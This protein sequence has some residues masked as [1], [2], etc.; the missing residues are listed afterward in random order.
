M[1]EA[2]ILAGGLGTRLRK[3]VS[4]LPKSLAEIND[5]PFLEYLMLFLKRNGFER[6]ILSLGYKS[7]QIRD[8]FGHEFQGMELDYAVEKE[9]LGTGG[10]IK[11]AMNQCKQEDVFVF[12]GD[13]LF[14]INLD[15]LEKFYASGNKKVVVALRKMQNMKRY[16]SVILDKDK[17][18]LK[19]QEKSRDSGVSYINGGI[20]V[21]NR[22]FYEQ[23]N[24][25]KVFSVEHDFFEKKCAQ[26]AIFAYPFDSYFIDIGVP[27]DLERAKHEFKN[28]DIF[29]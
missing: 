25:Q 9:Q 28:S 27:E 13:T 24:S 19:F 1:R 5:K 4:D 6:I 12:N 11:Y 29:S 20:Y 18:I 22:T 17:R 3:S 8:Y 14:L 16:G 26:T 2:V 21:I 7:E 23:N 15:E 10:A